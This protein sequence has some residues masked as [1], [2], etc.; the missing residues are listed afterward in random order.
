MFVVIFIW[1]I[2][3]SPITTPFDLILICIVSLLAQERLPHI[4]ATKLSPT[5][6]KLGGTLKLPTPVPIRDVSTV[7]SVIRGPNAV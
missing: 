6:K 2:P 1:K 3:K 7:V 5:L 4:L